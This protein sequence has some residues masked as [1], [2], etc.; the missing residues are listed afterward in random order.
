MSKVA[1]VITGAI[2][3]AL[4]VVVIAG[5]QHWHATSQLGKVDIIGMVTSQ[6]K[7]LS[8]Q[9]KPGMDEKA[10]A[11]LVTQATA[12][13]KQLEVALKQVSN[14]CNC[15]LIN[16]AAIVMDAPMGAMLDYSNR[17]NEL[18]QVKK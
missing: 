18:I 13:G 8:A 12:F 9:L 14:E 17:V 16:A 6:Q 10:Q 7:S 4:A 15:T 11:A 5:W 1:H 3:A 2:S